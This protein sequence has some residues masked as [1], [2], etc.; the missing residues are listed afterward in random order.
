MPD[1]HTCRA[2]AAGREGVS[3]EA[4]YEAKRKIRK[5]SGMQALRYVRARYVAAYIPQPTARDLS[6]EGLLDFFNE[7]LANDPKL[8]YE[9]SHLSASFREFALQAYDAGFA[10]GKLPEP[11]SEAKP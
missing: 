10:A 2:D 11:P 4:I 1:L 7:I 9:Y 5:E 3:D 6:D 8:Y